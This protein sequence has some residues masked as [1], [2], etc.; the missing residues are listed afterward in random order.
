[1]IKNAYQELDRLKA[2]PKAATALPAPASGWAERV[3]KHR[4]ALDVSQMVAAEQLG[5]SR[6]YLAQVER[7][8]E[9][10]PAL[11]AKLE[12]WITSR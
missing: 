8:H 4:Q 11:A 1:M 10:S 6:A 7:G 12:R 2:S 9:P 3:K 5:V